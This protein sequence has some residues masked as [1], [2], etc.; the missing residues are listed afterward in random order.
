VGVPRKKDR[1]ETVLVL[2]WRKTVASVWQY[3]LTGSRRSA[4]QEE[5]GIGEVGQWGEESRENPAQ[6]IAEQAVRLLLQT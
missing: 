5:G 3:L 4:Q 1:T 6:L 2:Q